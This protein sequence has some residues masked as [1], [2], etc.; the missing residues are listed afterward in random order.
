MIAT[1]RALDAAA[2]VDAGR[3][4]EAEALLEGVVG[5]RA[6]LERARIA[7][8]RGD[9]AALLAHATEAA[10]GAEA[11]GDGNIEGRARHMWGVALRE[12]GEDEGPML[13]HALRLIEEPTARAWCENE[14]GNYLLGRDRF[15]EALAA[16]DHAEAVAVET[17]NDEQMATIG[18][19]RAFA[20]YALE[21]YAETAAAA[22]A[23]ADLA[24]GL[25]QQPALAAALRIRALAL[26]ALG[27]DARAAVETYAAV[28]E[29]G[30]AWDRA[31]GPL[32]TARAAAR[33]EAFPAL[34]DEA[35]AYD[36]G[37][38][39]AVGRLWWWA[40]LYE[41]D[42]REA[43]SRFGELYAPAARDGRVF[44][45]VERRAVDYATLRLPRVDLA[46]GPLDLDAL[47]SR[48]TAA[49]YLAAYRREDG[50]STRIAKLIGHDQRAVSRQMRA[51]GL[52]PR[53]AGR[54]K[55]T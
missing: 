50:K 39:A 10:K 13:E 3:L 45:R 4:D 27:Q 49:V 22:T 29:A 14:Y 25:H 38:A 44:V 15:P 46:A 28:A 21:Q 12:H 17:S 33:L 40:T 23:V 35:R 30:A 47:R 36:G 24:G 37:Q 2:L 9:T 11:A 48:L 52:E 7:N 53:A 51:L 34:V 32:L 6:A 8:Y 54:P 42:P 19:A 41:R 31:V 1:A 43:C 5:Y 55:G 20:L 26:F 18:A 16:Y